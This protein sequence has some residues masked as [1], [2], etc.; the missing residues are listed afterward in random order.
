MMKLGMNESLS[1][2]RKVDRSRNVE[3]IGNYKCEGTIQGLGTRLT[4]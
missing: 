4:L 1:N 2:R 3:M